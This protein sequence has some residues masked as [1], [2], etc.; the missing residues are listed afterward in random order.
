MGYRAMSM[1]G[2]ALAALYVGLLAGCSSVALQDEQKEDEMDKGASSSVIEVSA[3][4]ADDYEVPDDLGQKRAQSRMRVKVPSGYDY[5]EQEQTYEADRGQEVD[6]S[7]IHIDMTEH[8]FSLDII[9]DDAGYLD[10][11]SGGPVLDYVDSVKD[12]PGNSSWHVDVG[13]Y[14]GVVLVQGTPISG[15]EMS[16]EVFVVLDDATIMISALSVDGEGQSSYSYSSFLRSKS[17]TD[18]LSQLTISVE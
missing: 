3:G 11:Y 14:D 10:W 18:L 13:G 16:G 17:V 6:L 7:T 9:V 15:G 4:F 12:N 5:S 2:L 1:V 8:G